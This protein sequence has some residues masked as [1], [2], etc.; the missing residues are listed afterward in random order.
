MPW[1]PICEDQNRLQSKFSLFSKWEDGDRLRK[2][3]CCFPYVMIEIGSDQ[4]CHYF[5]NG[6]IGIGSH[7]NY[8]IVFLGV[9]ED[10]FKPVKYILFRISKYYN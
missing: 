9:N 4:S 3:C 1:F 6:R 2:K 7:Q 10:V 8:Y 5:P